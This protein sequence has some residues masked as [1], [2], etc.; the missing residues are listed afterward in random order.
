MKLL[1]PDV[2]S[3]PSNW[4]AKAVQHFQARLQAENG[5]KRER[6]DVR[7]GPKV[8]ELAKKVAEYVKITV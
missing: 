4:Q 6:V 1:Q 3:P 7:F 8:A 2:P 5:S